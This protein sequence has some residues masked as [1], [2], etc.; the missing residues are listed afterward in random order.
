MQAAY[1]D[2][3]EAALKQI[4]AADL[5]VGIVARWDGRILQ[6]THLSVVE[7]EYVYATQAAKPVLIFLLDDS[8][9]WPEEFTEVDQPLWQF[10]TLLTR[11]RSV[12]FF[13]SLPEF[14]SKLEAAVKAWDAQRVTFDVTVD[15]LPL[16]WRLVAG[17]FAEPELLRHLDPSAFVAAIKKWEEANKADNNLPWPARVERARKTLDHA[18]TDYEVSA[19][20]LAPMPATRPAQAA[21]DTNTSDGTAM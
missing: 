17:S 9:S 8:A 1:E 21:G 11:E 16:A 3:V 19:L 4:A 2:P 13:A 5:F 6:A 14:Q 15:D 7:T 12:S 18:Q 10:R 20:R